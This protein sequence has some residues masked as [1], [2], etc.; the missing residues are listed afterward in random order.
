MQSEGQRNN[1]EIELDSVIVRPLLPG[2]KER[3]KALLDKHHYLG[4]ILL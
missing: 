1:L 3:F 2:E 4:A